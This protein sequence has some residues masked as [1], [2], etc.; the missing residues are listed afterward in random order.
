MN[1]GSLRSLF[2]AAILAFVPV[3]AAAAA[4][5]EG[6][7]QFIQTLATDAIEVLQSKDATLAERQTKFHALLK[8]RF[9]VRTIGRFVLG[10][11]WRRTTPE[12]R[13]K[14]FELFADWIAKTYAVRFGGYTDERFDVTGTRT[15]PGDG[16]VFVGTRI[17]KPNSSVA[18]KA[19]W[20]VRRINGS[21]KIIDVEVEGISMAMTQRAEFSSV[22]RREGIDGLLNILRERIDEIDRN[23]Y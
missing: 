14:Y 6:P 4:P 3:V 11:Y 18:Y 22:T 8:E 7:A 1:S 13:G 9:A 15:N 16:D 5:M 17:A 21:Y 19:N 10:R 20:R 12:Q 2:V 23:G